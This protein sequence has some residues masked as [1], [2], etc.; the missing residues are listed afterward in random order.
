MMNRRD[1]FTGASAV[2]IAGIAPKLASAKPE[3]FAGVDFGEIRHLIGKP[4][5]TAFHIPA[6]QLWSDGSVSYHD[7]GPTFWPMDYSHVDPAI[8]PVGVKWRQPAS[9]RK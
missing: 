9:E 1:L 8:R 5:M 7:D 3:R 4:M 2:A 6:H